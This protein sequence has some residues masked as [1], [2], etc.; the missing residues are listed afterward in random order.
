[1]QFDLTKALADQILFSM[2]DQED[3]HFLDTHEGVVVPVEEMREEEDGGDRYLPIPEW[4]SSDGFHLM[5]RFAAGLRNP[6]VREELTVALD[7]GKG[8]FRAFKDVLTRHPEVER[9]WFSFKEKEM[10][11]SIYDWYNAL[12]ESWGLERLG[13]EPEETG[14][15]ILEDFRFR[16]GEDRDIPASK[17]LHEQCIQEF[18]MG[19]GGSD[20][21]DLGMAETAERLSR[22]RLPA[23]LWFISETNRGDFA[24]YC[25]ARR[26]GDSVRLVALEV[27]PEYR[28]LGIGE[29]L[30]LRLMENIDSSRTPHFLLD[31][32]SASEGFS[33]VLARSGFTP[34]ET[35]YVVNLAKQGGDLS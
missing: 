25:A 20:S 1:M 24:G 23:D 31:L 2:E 4:A 33:R 13:E 28:G 14:D 16:E 27:A 3:E 9:L 10:R 6:L 30:L 7:R 17:L 35:R 5:E 11:R 22:L 32:P 8:V 18:L 21:S 26:E 12:R 34:Y 19:H 15:L 29:A